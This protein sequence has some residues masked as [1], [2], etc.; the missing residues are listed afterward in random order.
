MEDFKSKLEIYKSRIKNLLKEANE[1][2]EKGY[3]LGNPSKVRRLRNDFFPE[4]ESIGRLGNFGFVCIGSS[5]KEGKGYDFE[6]RGLGIKGSGVF[7]LNHLLLAITNK[8]KIN[9]NIDSPMLNL[10]K[11]FSYFEEIF[12][13]FEKRFYEYVDNLNLK[14]N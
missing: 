13:D 14:E 1:I 7:C 3:P 9:V 8:D 2:V 6:I 5:S 10:F 12:E 4:F 11:D